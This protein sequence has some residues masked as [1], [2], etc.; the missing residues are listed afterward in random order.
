MKM[1]DIVKGNKAVFTHYRLGCL[2]Y[3]IIDGGTGE[4][5]CSV[6]V[7]VDDKDDIG[8]ATYNA[9]VKAISLMRYVRK[10]NVTCPP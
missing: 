10:L 5:I 2:H 4:R 7:N 1:I 8:H 3:D 9:E 6:P